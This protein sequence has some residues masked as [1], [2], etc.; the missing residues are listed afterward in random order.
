MYFLILSQ[1]F[2]FLCFCPYKDC[3]TSI[4]RRLPVFWR[5]VKYT[6][7]LLSLQCRLY[8]SFYIGLTKHVSIYMPVR[9]KNEQAHNSTTSMCVKHQSEQ[10]RVSHFFARKIRAVVSSGR[11]HNSIKW[12]TWQ[13]ACPIALDCETLGI[14]Q[15]LVPLV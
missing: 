2:L 6:I 13:R 5:L 10:D 9:C 3:I 1:T 11:T 7:I 8:L 14:Q 4:T 12:L 15:Y